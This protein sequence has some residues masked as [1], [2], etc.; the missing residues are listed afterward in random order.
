MKTFHDC[1]PC[2]MRQTIQA[3]KQISDDEQL[4]ERVLRSALFLAS[5]MDYSKTPALI[6]REIHALIRKETINNDPYAEIKH[7][8]NEI[9][10]AIAPAIREEITTCDNPLQMAI[11]FAIAGNILDFALYNGWD[12][13]RFQE[14]LHSSRTKSIDKKQLDRLQAEIE[15]ADNI[16]ILGDNAGETVFDRLLIEQ[17][18]PKQITYAVK[19][20]PVIN[21]A[22][23]EDAIF[24]GIDKF[25]KIIDTGMD[26]AGTLLSMCSRVFLD[27]F[28]NADL[29]IA[30]G[31]ANYETLCDSQRQVFF[32]TQIKC[33]VI[34]Q[35]LNGNVG[36]WIIAST[37]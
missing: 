15:K 9:A 21:D 32:L 24:A 20:Y 7:K 31:Q 23:R 14:S 1:I 4:I 33:D 18:M 37:Q 8:A 34:A 17:I 35:D 29:V 36:D 6:G 12:D 2:L 19:G 28:Y 27:I 3:V 25:A 5:K 10:L 26:C 11:R 13:K 22:L 30:K 16:L